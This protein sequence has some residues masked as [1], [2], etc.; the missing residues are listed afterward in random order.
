MTDVDPA[1]VDATRAR[2]PVKRDRRPDLY[3]R[4][5]SGKET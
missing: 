3:H 1:R 4:L 2:M 5:L